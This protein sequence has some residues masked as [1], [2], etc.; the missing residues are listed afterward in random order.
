MASSLIVPIVEVKNIRPHPNADN[1][2]L[3]DVLGYQMCI[4]KNKYHNG[5]RAVYFPADTL[6]PNDIA[7]SLG[8]RNFLK[9]KDQDRVGKNQTSWRTFIW[10]Y[11]HHTG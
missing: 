3:C 5:D 8:V 4:P 1:L 9:G 7:D 6:I 11:H 10:T 2:E